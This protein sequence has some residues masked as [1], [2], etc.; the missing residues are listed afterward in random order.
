MQYRKTV[1]IEE[2]VDILYK[3]EDDKILYF[4]GD[5][6]IEEDECDYTN[7]YGMKTTKL[8]EEDNLLA[9]G[10]MGGGYTETYDD[11]IIDTEE[12]WKESYTRY[13]KDFI[14][15]C[16]DFDNEN[17]VVIGTYYLDK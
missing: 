12:E 8:F 13:I 2:L 9:I 5:L 1:T 3:F 14:N 11:P 4:C 16:M 15:N 6:D 10:C 7:W 17:K